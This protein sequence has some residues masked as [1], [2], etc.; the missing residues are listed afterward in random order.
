[1]ELRAHPAVAGRFLLHP[2]QAM[3]LLAFGRLS[4]LVPKTPVQ[5]YE[6]QAP[7]DLIHID[8]KEMDR[9][10]KLGHRISCNR[11]Q[12]RSIGVRFDRVHVGIDDPT[13]LAVAPLGAFCIISGGPL[14]R[15]SGYGHRLRFRDCLPLHRQSRAWSAGR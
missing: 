3:T 4:N 14:L 10:R 1:M 5:R 12:V 6:R 11:Q 2:G 13:R 7:G 8:A 15:A 9:F